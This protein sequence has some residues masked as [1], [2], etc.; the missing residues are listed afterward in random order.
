MQALDRY[1]MPLY[2]LIYVSLFVIYFTYSMS[3]AYCIRICIV[4]NFLKPF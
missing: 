4:F 1:I 3:T 2:K